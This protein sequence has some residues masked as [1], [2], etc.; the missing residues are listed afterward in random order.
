MKKN[1]INIGIVAAF[2]I[3]ALLNQCRDTNVSRESKIA[4]KI[5]FNTVDVKIEEILTPPTGTQETEIVEYY[6]EE[7]P[8][9]R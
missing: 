1:K 4:D 3:I 5:K 6:M 8:K 7:V 2:A 9:T